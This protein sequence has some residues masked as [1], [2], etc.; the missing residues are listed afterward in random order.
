MRWLLRSGALLAA[1]GNR[2]RVYRVDTSVSG[3]FTD[4]AHVEAAQATGV[5]GGEGWAAGGDE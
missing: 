4:L 1:T 2:G 5:C 3:Q